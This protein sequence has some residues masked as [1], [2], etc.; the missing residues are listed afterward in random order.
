MIYYDTQEGF[1]ERMNK[2]LLVNE[3][4]LDDIADLKEKLFWANHLLSNAYEILTA[5]A[6]KDSYELLD[7]IVLHLKECRENE[8]SAGNKDNGHGL[9][10]L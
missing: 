8:K 9:S 5:T 6:N 2:A 3:Q 1:Q 10:D 7:C 4:R